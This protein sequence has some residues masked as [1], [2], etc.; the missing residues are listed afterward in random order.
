MIKNTS[1]FLIAGLILAWLVDFFFFNK[2]FGI[3]FSIWIFIAAGCLFFV[4]WHEKIRPHWLSILLAG[5]T[6]AISTASFIRQEPFT[7]AVSALA[8]LALLMLITITFRNGNWPFFRLLDYILQGLKWLVM[9]FSRAWPL[10]FQGQKKS[11]QENIDPSEQTPQKNKPLWPVLR[12]LLLALP[13]ILILAALLAGA[14]PI[15]EQGLNKFLEIFRIENLAEYIFRTVNIL[16]MAYLFIG[17]LIQAIHPTKQDPRPH[18]NQ[19]SIKKFLGSLETSIVFG[20]INLLFGT[21]LVIQFR[22]FFGGQANISETGFTYA[23]YARRGFGELITVAVLSL[24]IYY[25]FHSITRMETTN[26]KRTFSGLSI[27]IFLQVLVMLV[28]SFQR[29]ALY[30]NAYG[31]SRL[32]TYSH[33][34]LPWLA[35]LIIVVIIL[36]ILQ[37]QGH[38][39][40]T[41]LV[42]AAGFVVTCIAFNIDGFIA[43]Q[44]I[45]RATLSDQ[46]GYALDFYYISELS[47]DAVPVILDGFRTTTSLTKDL[48]GADLAC[49]W[50]NMQNDETR[51]WQSFN[52]SFSRAKNLLELN[53]DL[54]LQY[55]VEQDANGF[56]NFVTIDD[57]SYYC[58]WTDL[59]M[60]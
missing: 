40:F 49:R 32:R 48:L 29:L 41:I 37:R 26:Q 6:I 5:I 60:D 9:I 59:F 35:A 57:E 56:Q 2:P 17:V 54:W 15:F 53:Q 7:L 43:R 21:F 31:F 13:I 8:S 16:F 11:G 45:Q 3:A 36:E 18:P 55:P 58:T 24:I 23:E 4:S 47:T 1:R 14:D 30:E 27:L 50:Y 20:S 33:L 28:S 46:E 44:N 39:A 10:I 22:Y 19:P 12:G 42:V 51:P 38:L 25:L 52:L 34:F